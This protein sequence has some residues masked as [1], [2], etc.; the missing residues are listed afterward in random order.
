MKITLLQ[1]HP[2][3]PATHEDPAKPGVLK[4]VLFNA[5]D[6][7]P[8]SGLKMLNY[9]VIQPGEAFQ[10]HHHETLEEVFYVLSGVGELVVGEETVRIGAEMAVLIPPNTTHMMKNVGEEPLIYLAFGAQTT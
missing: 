8:E 10:P 7:S 2:L 3:V 4:R 6:F 5:D 1:D 9:A